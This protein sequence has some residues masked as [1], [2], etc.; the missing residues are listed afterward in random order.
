MIRILLAGFSRQ[1]N[2]KISNFTV[3]SDDSL[4]EGVHKFTSMMSALIGRR[5]Y[6]EKVTVRERRA[7][8]GET[9][10]VRSYRRR[11]TFATCRSHDIN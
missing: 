8:R 11:K 4:F 2:L 10:R 3:G 7:M 5:T 9:R 1:R 6:R